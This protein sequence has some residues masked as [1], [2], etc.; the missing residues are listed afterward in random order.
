MINAPSWCAE[1]W[2]AM[3]ALRNLGFS[4]DDL[5]LGA[6]NVVGIGPAVTV[7]LRP[8]PEPSEKLEFNWTID[9]LDVKEQREAEELVKTVWPSFVRDINQVTQA[10]RYAIFGPWITRFP[11]YVAL[12]QA[13]AKKGI[14]VPKLEFGWV[15]APE[16]T[17]RS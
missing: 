3:Q 17:V 11:G 15:S 9:R 8:G 13:I 14:T 4:A 5:Y 16:G 10:E 2:C 6:A 7:T 12:A 1:A